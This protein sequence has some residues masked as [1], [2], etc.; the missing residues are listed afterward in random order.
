MERN[1]K[2]VAVDPDGSKDRKWAKKAN[3][4]NLFHCTLNHFT[5]RLVGRIFAYLG[6][7]EDGRIIAKVCGENITID[8]M[9]IAHQF[10]VSVEGVV[11]VANMLVKEA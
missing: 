11:N 4:G 8:Q 9:L 3:L 10:G 1:I 6:G 2:N 5:R 7:H